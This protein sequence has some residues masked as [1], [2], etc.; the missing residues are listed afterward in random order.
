MPH[1]ST[2]FWTASRRLWCAVIVLA[3]LVLG[4]SGCLSRLWSRLRAAETC[5]T[6]AEQDRVKR[7]AGILRRLE[8]IYAAVEAGRK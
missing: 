4:Q 7:D 6:A 2:T 3:L 8:S 1:V 5:A